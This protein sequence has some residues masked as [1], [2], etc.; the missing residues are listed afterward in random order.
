[1]P[2]LSRDVG[3]KIPSADWKRN[4]DAP[5]TA[6]AILIEIA[7]NGTGRVLVGDRELRS[8]PFQHKADIAGHA[9]REVDDLNAGPISERP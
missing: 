1:M 9:A 7:Q 3:L 8:A 4:T 2:K 6:A 5:A